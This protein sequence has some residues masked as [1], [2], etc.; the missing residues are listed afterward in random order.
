[1]LEGTATERDVPCANQV[2]DLGLVFGGHALR[3]ES[4]RERVVRE[5]V[6]HNVHGVVVLAVLP[7]GFGPP[8]GALVA[9]VALDH[10][11]RWVHSE[12]V[13]LD[14]LLIGP[15]TSIELV[16]VVPCSSGEQARS[17]IVGSRG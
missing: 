1:M 16:W 6:G 5:P 2:T 13:Q 11:P 4:H 15:P 17:G 9:E 14:N 7:L 3:F 10:L 8:G 12:G